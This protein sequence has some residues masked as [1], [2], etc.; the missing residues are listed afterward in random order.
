MFFQWNLAHKNKVF[1]IDLKKKQHKK[2]EESKS[3]IT[4]TNSS[5]KEKKEDD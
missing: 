3:I 4:I 5:L 1:L 2:V